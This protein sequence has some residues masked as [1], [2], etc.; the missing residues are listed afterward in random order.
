MCSKLSSELVGKAVDNILAYAA[1]KEYTVGDK[2]IKGKKRN[3]VE[4]VE[5]Q[6]GTLWRRVVWPHPR[7]FTRLC[8]RIQA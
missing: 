8:A 2:T 4:T 5:L 1:G 3:F 7:A 6:I